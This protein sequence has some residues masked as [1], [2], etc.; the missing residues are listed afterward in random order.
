MKH[1]AIIVYKSST[2]FTKRYAEM[3]AQETSCA[4]AEFKTVTAKHLSAYDTVL[5]GSRAHGSPFL[6]AKRALL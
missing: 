2:G 4:L 5:F 3:I 6:S 1:K